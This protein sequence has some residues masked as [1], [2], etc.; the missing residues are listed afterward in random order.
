AADLPDSMADAV[1]RS[2]ARR[3][4]PDAGRDRGTCRL[5]IASG[6]QQG[7]QATDRREAFILAEAPADRKKIFPPPDG[8]VLDLTPRLPSGR[9]GRPGRSPAL[10]CIREGLARWPGS[11]A[12]LLEH[13]LDATPATHALT[14]QIR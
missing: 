4:E 3:R 9:R 13:P 2:A 12:L 1:R 7:L 14:A 5:R 8:W 6:V 11:L 10:V